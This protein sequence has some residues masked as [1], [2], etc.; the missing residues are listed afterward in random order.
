[1]NQARGKR[2]SAAA[3]A[4]QQKE[5]GWVARIS[6]TV[7]MRSRQR[8]TAAAQG[9]FR[10][11]PA[12]PPGVAPSGSGMA[13]DDA[14]SA[15]VAWAAQAFYGDS[16][17][18]LGYPYLAELAQRPEYRRISET[19]ALY[20]TH[21][22]IKIKAG[23]DDS[24]ADKIGKIESEFKRLNVQQ[25]FKRIAE[26]DG[27]F[28]RAHLYLDFG[29]SDDRE[30]LTKPIGDG[31]NEMSR[32][33]VARGSLKALRPIE[34]VWCYPT[35]YN[36][37]DPLKPNW[38]RPDAW[39]VMGKE[40]HASRLLTFVGRE[41]A[42]LLKPAYS[43]GGLSM[44]QI[45]KPY[46]ENWIRTRQSVADILSAF[47]VMVLKTRLAD[48]LNTGGAGSDIFARA[49]LFN[50]LRDNRGLFI[51]DKDSEDFSNVSAPLS[52]LD[53]LQAQTQEHMA[54]VSGIPIVILLGIQPAGMNATSEGELRT[55]YNWVAA[56][57]E[58]L[59][60]PNLE[61]ILG[62]VQLSLF[63][64]IDPEIVFEFEPLES[65]DE[66]ERAEIELTEA[67]TDQ[68]LVDSAIITTQEAR[69]QMASRESSRY[70]GLNVDDVPLPSPGEMEEED[71]PDPA[72]VEP[73][74]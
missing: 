36:A 69:T 66:K 29:T 53:A 19:L 13:Q 11:V 32:S 7:L 10:G 58:T 71:L 67:Q 38:Y 20:M 52:G 15:S 22:W 31:R 72:L 62:F 6:D 12:H 61:R 18:F 17:S 57:Q 1:M 39:F 63:G 68:V 59:F 21:R 43:F 14:L 30:E 37:N 41:V 25:A 33:K 45:A 24:K 56:L 4:E 73:E 40:L 70:Q 60:R 64:E 35:N 46:V 8:R 27:F 28:G 2:I 42:D 44:S 26:Q 49:E 54:A 3:P 47:S 16:L 74:S 23:G 51:I 48:Q 5:R 65:I 34:A 50:N 55:F 9:P